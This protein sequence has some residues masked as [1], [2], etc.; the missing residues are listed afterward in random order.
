M[1]NAFH[2]FNEIEMKIR[3]HKVSNRFGWWREPTKRAIAALLIGLLGASVANPVTADDLLTN[4]MQQL[5]E[6]SNF[7]RNL[8]VTTAMQ[9]TDAEGPKF[10]PVY[11]AYLNDLQDLN[12]IY[13]QI[14]QSYVFARRNRTLSDDQARQLT[15]QFLA[16]QEKELT[17]RKTYAANLAKVL[18]GMTAARAVQL[19]NKIRAVAWYGLSS[20][21]PLAKQ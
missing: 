14:I 1:D 7:D 17:L 15:D 19:E 11:E 18:P 21:L 4:Q 12:R 16:T 5:Q 20:Q 2:E 6:K 9:L 3:Q 8:V 10:W 13:A